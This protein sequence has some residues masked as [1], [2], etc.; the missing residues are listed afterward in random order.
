MPSRMNGRRAVENNL[1][2]SVFAVQR[3]VEYAD[4]SARMRWG[5]GVCRHVVGVLRCQEHG[6][7]EFSE[8]LSSGCAVHSR[9]EGK[10]ARPVQNITVGYVNLTGEECIDLDY[11]WSY[12]Y[13][14][15]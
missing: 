6:S 14:L 1:G 4:R 9:D 3:F 12:S 13:V 5:D 2:R 8:K 10:R 7:G 11:C 15:Y